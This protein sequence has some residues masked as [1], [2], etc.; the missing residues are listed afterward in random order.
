VVR[1]LKPIDLVVAGPTASGKTRLAIAWAQIFNAEI[2]SADSRQ[3]YREIS[4]GTGKPSRE[5]R[6]LVPHHLFDLCSVTETYSA[7]DF[8]RDAKSAIRDI[9]ERGKRVVVCG[10]TG[11]YMKALLR[12]LVDLP[13]RDF[14]R[15]E[16]YRKDQESLSTESLYDRLMEADP[17]R[18]TAIHPHDRVRILRAMYLMEKYSAPPTELYERFRGEGVLAL[19]VVGLDPGRETL[20][21]SISDRV[22]RMLREGWVDEVKSLL[23]AGASPT[24]PGFNSLGY[25]EILDCLLGKGL[26]DTLE[27]RI[28]L[29]TRQ[30][31]KRQMT[32]FRH[33]E[34]ITWISPSDSGSFFLDPSSNY[35]TIKTILHDES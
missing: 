11:L 14:S 17:A 16:L 19:R 10:G 3:I 8:V 6:D 31:A 23:K 26:W 22:S 5:E 4:I 7:G 18:G 35:G 28:V 15:Y 13:E 20:H 9:Q 12:G 33:M 30:Y 32:W 1:P 34:D 29:K 21:L 27:S 25:Q 2:I 24:A